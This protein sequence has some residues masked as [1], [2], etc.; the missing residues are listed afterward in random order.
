M[1]RPDNERA[2]LQREVYA[3]LD[4]QSAINLRMNYLINELSKKHGVTRNIYNILRFL[5][6][7][8]D[9]VEPSVIAQN[10]SM[11][12]QSISNTVFDLEKRGLVESKNHPT[13]RRRILIYL[14]PEGAE[15]EKKLS[16]EMRALHASVFAHFTNEEMRTYLD[17]RNRIIQ[18]MQEV[19]RENY[20][21][22]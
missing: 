16:Q 5:K 19:I 6:R 14:S 15:L 9:G 10:L 13:D 11:L 8:P 22:L 20:Q 17:L 3:T 12:R 7:H 2:K 18:C 1:S 21:V 4:S